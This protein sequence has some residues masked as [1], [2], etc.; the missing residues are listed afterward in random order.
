MTKLRKGGHE[1]EVDEY[2]DATCFFVLFCFDK[3]KY[4]KCALNL[5]SEP[6]EKL[7]LD[8]EV[9]GVSLPTLQINRDRS[10]CT[11]YFSK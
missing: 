6:L 7:K 4:E 8:F 5:K 10:F 11:F 1:C 2:R 3:Q 9:L